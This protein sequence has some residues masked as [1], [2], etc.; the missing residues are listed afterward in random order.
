MLQRRHVNRSEAFEMDR[1]LP[2]PFLNQGEHALLVAIGNDGREDDGLGWAFAKALQERGLFKG[3]VAFRYQLQVEDADL[4]KDFPAVLFADAWKTRQ[5]EPF[6]FAPCRPQSARA[7][8]THAL[9]PQSV[10][11]LCQ[12][13]YGAA[14]EAFLLGIRGASWD[15]RIGL[16]PTGEAHLEEAVRVWTQKSVI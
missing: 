5:N 9:S 6:Y 2:A 3:A 1:P 14:P 13:V 16:S 7:F 11:H 12:A 10:L 8:S 15:L 4:L